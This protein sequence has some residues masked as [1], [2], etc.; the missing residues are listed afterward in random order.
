[1]R[2]DMHIREQKVLTHTIIVIICQNRD[3]NDIIRP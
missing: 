3:F 2:A 1:M